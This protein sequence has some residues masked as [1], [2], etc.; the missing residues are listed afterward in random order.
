MKEYFCCSKQN[1]GVYPVHKKI[2]TKKI[3]KDSYNRK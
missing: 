1:K 3:K 2:N